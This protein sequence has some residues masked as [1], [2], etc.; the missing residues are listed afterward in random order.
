MKVRDIKITENEKLSY[1]WPLNDRA[2]NK[3]TEVQAGKDATVINPKWLRRAHSEWSELIKFD[4][5]GRAS[6]A[7]NPDRDEVYIVGTNLFYTFSINSKTLTADSYSSGPSILM[8]GNQSYY[9]KEGHQ[10]YNLYIDQDVVSAYDW[11]KRSWDKKP[12]LP[13]S[14]TNFWHFNK[15]WSPTEKAFYTFNG[16]GHFKYKNI[17]RRFDVTTGKTQTL[18]PSGDYFAPRYLAGLGPVKDGAYLIGGYGS[19]SGEQIASPKNFYD[20][21]YYSIKN[22]SLRKVYQL[23]ETQDDFVFSNS[24]VIDEPSHSYYGLIFQ[25]HKYNSHLQLVKGSLIKPEIEK[26][27]NQVPFTF[28]DNNTFSDLFYSDRAK[29]FV[30]V[31]L[32][33]NTNQV[34]EVSIYSLASP[35]LPAEIITSN[36]ATKS[37]TWWYLWAI[38]LLVVTIIIFLRLW[39]IKTR[40]YKVIRQAQPDFAQAN[41]PTLSSTTLDLEHESAAEDQQLFEPAA[42]E[43]D[44]YAQVG[45]IYLFGDFEVFDSENVDITKHFTPLIKELFLVILIYTIKWKRG[46]SSDELTELLWFDKSSESARNNRSVNIAKLKIILDR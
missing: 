7:F 21:F 34:S 25:K 14:S 10:L 37:W 18:K 36:Q 27:G 38:T 31:T 22:N 2:N 42:F 26:L 33:V 12:T 46:I 9:A 29:T 4:A 41:K 45:S 3:A 13:D 32:R 16:Y 1:H 24:L 19:V 8:K 23:K 35:P 44:Q 15:L 28:Y 43:S 17:I 30:A 5:K 40:S 11:S 39:Y 6:V 20:L